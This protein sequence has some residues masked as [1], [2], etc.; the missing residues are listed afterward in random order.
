M[1]SAVVGGIVGGLL[2]P[3]AILVLSAGYQWWIESGHAH[4]VLEQPIIETAVFG[5]EARIRIRLETAIK[6]TGGTA[7]GV[8]L[9]YSCIENAPGMSEFDTV[10]NVLTPSGIFPSSPIQASTFDS[11]RADCPSDDGTPIEQSKLGFIK[12]IWRNSDA[13]VG[14]SCWRVAMTNNMFIGSPGGEKYEC[15]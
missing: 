7:R 10:L 1:K 12:I 15:P 11:Y 5:G 6:A 14:Q 4:V 2:S 13:S 8:R 3:L 9:S